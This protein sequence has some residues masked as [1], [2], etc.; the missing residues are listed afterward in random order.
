MIG[1]NNSLRVDN[2]ANEPL[3]ESPKTDEESSYSVTHA[4]PKPVFDL[5]ETSQQFID[6]F[7]KQESYFSQNTQEFV[8]NIF[9]HSFSVDTLITDKTLI[10]DFM[11]ELRTAIQNAIVMCSSIN[12]SRSYENERLTYPS[13]EEMKGLVALILDIKKKSNKFKK[14]KEFLEQFDAIFAPF[15]THIENQIREQAYRSRALQIKGLENCIDIDPEEKCYRLAVA[16][17]HLEDLKNKPGQHWGELNAILNLSR[18]DWI[19]R[20]ATSKELKFFHFITT[21]YDRQHT[22]NPPS[23]LIR[24]EDL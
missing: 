15:L 12:F 11:C 4:D 3:S 13:T 9:D 20:E 23:F 7:F 16:K 1:P 24:A 6:E 2:Y 8:R 19:E 18:F 22:F 17:H 10:Q 14:T 21:I 5:R